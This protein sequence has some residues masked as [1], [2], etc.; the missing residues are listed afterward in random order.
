MALLMTDNF[1]PPECET[2]KRRRLESGEQSDQHILI[3]PVQIDRLCM[4]A[5]NFNCAAVLNNEISRLQLSSLFLKYKAVVLF[6]Y[7]CDL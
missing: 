2:R 4:T 6:F 1:M 5:P 7:E 3:N